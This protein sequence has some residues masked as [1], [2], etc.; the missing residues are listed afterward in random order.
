[1]FTRDHRIA[2]ISGK[3]MDANG[4]QITLDVADVNHLL[5]VIAMQE[6][7]LYEYEFTEQQHHVEEPAAEDD[8]TDEYGECTHCNGQGC[9]WC[10][11]YR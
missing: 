6:E 7:R 11:G 8:D 2:D 9:Y 5:D 1:M 3:V 4:D 10:D